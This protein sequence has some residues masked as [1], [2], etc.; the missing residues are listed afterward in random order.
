MKL[1]IILCLLNCI[2][3]IVQVTEGRKYLPRVPHVGSPVLWCGN[4][5]APQ[6]T[7][8]NEPLDSYEMCAHVYQITE[9][10][11]GFKTQS[12]KGI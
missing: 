11:N 7:L 9:N 8:V 10:I 1:P 4:L 3:E 12:K 5:L 2:T 6:S